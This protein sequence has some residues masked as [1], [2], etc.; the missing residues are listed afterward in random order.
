MKK[1]MIVFLAILVT[2]VI[3]YVL[4]VI[5]PPIVDY[6]TEALSRDNNG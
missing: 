6:I 4:S 3:F 2:I 5:T 1:I